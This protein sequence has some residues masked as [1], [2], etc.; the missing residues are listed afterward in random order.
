MIIYFSKT[1]I[2]KKKKKKLKVPCAQ[3]ATVQTNPAIIGTRTTESV[4]SQF[5]FYVCSYVW[6]GSKNLNR[7]ITYF[8]YV[9]T[10]SK[11]YESNRNSTQSLQLSRSSFFR[12]DL[13][14]RIVWMWR[15]FI[16]L[17]VLTLTKERIF[18]F[19]RISK[20]A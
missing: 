13:S 10:R 16:L 18:T 3:S 17:N 6:Q 12:Q 1:K 15:T 7:R 9:N 11:S 20:Q 2:E 19:F 8:I 14:V 4:S 5:F